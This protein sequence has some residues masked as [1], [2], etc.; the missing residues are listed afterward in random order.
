MK[1]KNQNTVL[2]VLSG[3]GLL[4][5]STGA[6]AGVM[7]AEITY[8]PNIGGGGGTGGGPGTGAGV[9]SV[10]TLSEWGLIAMALLVAVMAYRALRSVLP[11]QPLAVLFLAGVLG[12]SMFGNTELMLKAMAETTDSFLYEPEGGV[13]GIGNKTGEVRLVNG[14]AAPQQIKRME[15]RNAHSLSIPSQSPPCEVGTVL[16]KDAACYLKIEF[17]GV[18]G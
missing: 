12:M 13:F 4:A 16:Q 11:R 8:S 9:Q 14:T 10:P 7:V 6:D 18:P 15:S 2:H 3:L 17:T 5:L 1:T